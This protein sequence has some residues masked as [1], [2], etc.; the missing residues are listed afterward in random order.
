MVK[1][2]KKNKKIALKKKRV[3][4]KVIRPHKRFLISK[5]IKSSRK[6]TKKIALIKNRKR[7]FTRLKK[8]V[9]RLIRRIKTKKTLRVKPAIKRKKQ[10][11]KISLKKAKIIK[12]QSSKKRQKERVVKSPPLLAESF[13]PKIK[14]IGIGGGG[15]SIVSE[16]GKSLDKA[17]FLV[18]D[19]DIRTLKN[20]QG[21][22]HLLLGQELTRGLGTGLN[23]NLAKEVARR[24]KDKISQ[25]F[26]DQDIIIF[27]ACLG[28]G[29]GSGATQ[30]FLDLN[31]DFSGITLG[32]FTLPFKFEG[33]S[34]HKIAAKALREIRG[35]LNVSIT[36][37][38]EKIF[39]I[40]GK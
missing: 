35:S 4:I 10:V 20:K 36:I 27:I 23:V 24:E 22:K 9:N 16:I 13:K 11:V 2:K 26:K 15:A 33:K 5:K 14:V 37:P 30:V 7:T 31:R 21:I 29:L 8:K 40:G 34:K 25:L 6:K 38:N 17:S 39:K 1:L 12:V 3:K 18:A 19:T 32:I 28:G